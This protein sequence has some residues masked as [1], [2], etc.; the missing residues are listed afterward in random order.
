MK[1]HTLLPI[2]IVT[3]L[4]SSV[5]FAQEGELLASD[6]EAS[7]STTF[8]EMPKLEITKEQMEPKEQ[9]AKKKIAMYIHQG[10]E[11]LDFAGPAEVFKVS[12]FETYTVGLTKDP[13]VSQGFITIVPEYSIDD[14][15]KPDI[16]AVFG[17]NGWKASPAVLT[18]PT[19]A[20]RTGLSRRSAWLT[21]GSLEYASS[22]VARR[23]KM[24]RYITV[25]L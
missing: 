10:M 20:R 23:I 19:S 9:S 18:C 25:I 2:W 4:I 16:I 22:A 11:I 1:K 6:S 24:M 7:V 15:P 3:F 8:K 21:G 12:G 5:A 13:I 17:G 14:C